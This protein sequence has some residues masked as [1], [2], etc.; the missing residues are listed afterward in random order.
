MINMM[1][2]ESMFELLAK[3][4]QLISIAFIFKL[5]II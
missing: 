4:N 5:L 1:L 3:Y 2:T